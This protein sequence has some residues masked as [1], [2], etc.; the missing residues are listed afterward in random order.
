VEGLKACLTAH[1]AHHQSFFSPRPSL[2]LRT[3]FPGI[4]HQHW[5]CKSYPVLLKR[6]QPHWDDAPDRLHAFLAEHF[7]LALASCDA[8]VPTLAPSPAAP[9]C[10]PCS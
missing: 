4:Q 7:A 8:P 9:P 2:K 1:L 10:R 6:L 5:F 3:E